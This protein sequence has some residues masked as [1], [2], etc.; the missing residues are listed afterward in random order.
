MRYWRY[1][2]FVLVLLSIISVSPASTI[3][4][5]P[6][7]IRLSVQAGYDGAYRP[8]DWFPVIVDI[9]NDG[10]DLQSTL[11][12]SFPGSQR[13]D[14]FRQVLNLP[15][16]AHK[17]LRMMVFT[18]DFVQSGQLRVLTS[19]P[20]TQR[21]LLNALDSTTFLIGV[22]SSDPALLNSLASL[23][24]DTTSGTTIQHLEA[25]QIPEQAVALHSL[26]ALVLHDLD[27]ALF[28]PAQRAAVS[29]WVRLGG[30]IIVSG[31][32]DAQHNSAGIA[33]LLPVTVGEVV[34]GD[35]A[36]LIDM[37]PTGSLPQGA[38][39]RN[40][41]QIRRGAEQLPAR[42]PL[43]ARWDQ[44][45]GSATFMAF[46][47][48][49]LRGWRD[50]ATLWEQL[51]TVKPFF[52]PGVRARQEQRNLLQ[53]SF[54]KAVENLP[55]TMLLFCFLVLY[56][57]VIGP[58]NYFFLRR[59]QQLERAWLSIPICVVVFAIGLYAVGSVLR[60]FQTQVHQV[61]IVQAREGQPHGLATSFVG[62]FSPN[63]QAYTLSFPAISLV[64]P[65]DS[66]GGLTSERAFIQSSDT[67][68]T[69]PDVLIDV[70]STQTFL[71]ETQIDMPVQLQSA[72][73]RSQ[74]SVQG[75]IRNTGTVGLRDA[76]VVYGSNAESIGTLEPG[77]SQSVRLS[78]TDQNFPYS[79]DVETLGGFDRNDILYWLFQDTA[80]TTI[81]PHLPLTT[82]AYLIAW[83]DQPSISV[84]TTAQQISRDGLTLYV[85]QLNLNT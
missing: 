31:G 37:M 60:G 22:L 20:I 9:A 4:Q 41:F 1:G 46:D 66:D 13:S 72:L 64:S 73:Q 74:D 70:G 35:L 59:R 25:L 47:I 54:R 68:I 85:I 58:L 53:S 63:R 40:A 51:L 14:V 81:A 83:S 33:D 69:I 6:S 19:P 27:T 29:E 18:Q 79:I 78:I 52:M 15:R 34:P 43:I 39:T 65:F 8:G 75:E 36:P 57:L 12:W 30:Q 56:I 45:A 48:A 80:S 2:A 10:P 24:L 82:P 3:A 67:G 38:S 5:S 61:S 84:N 11:E 50:E 42:D 44:G 62:V 21:V 17:R 23:D 49:R 26:N 76:F 32:A 16:G 28:S 77:T 7:G 71:A 55:S